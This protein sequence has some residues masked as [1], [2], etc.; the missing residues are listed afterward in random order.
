MIPE[1]RS[2]SSGRSGSLIQ[3]L[4]ATGDD[5]CTVMAAGH[6][7]QASAI[8]YSRLSLPERGS[9]ALLAVRLLYDLGFVSEVPRAF[10]FADALCHSLETVLFVA[11]DCTGIMNICG[12]W[13]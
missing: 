1:Q 4:T 7:S 5:G 12:W 11:S 13:P 6:S 10:I 8:H 3:S 2:R 9:K